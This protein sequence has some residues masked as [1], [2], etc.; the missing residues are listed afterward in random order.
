VPSHL[1][2]SHRNLDLE[3]EFQQHVKRLCQGA[4][5][6]RGVDFE[7]SETNME[8]ELRYIQRK[9]PAIQCD[10]VDGAQTV[11]TLRRH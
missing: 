11:S 1:V 3:A 7:F 5:I 9:F 4:N 10:K 6:N 8:P 2:P